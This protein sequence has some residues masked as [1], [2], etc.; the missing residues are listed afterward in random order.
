MAQY[1]FLRRLLGRKTA[2]PAPTSTAAPAA[3]AAT[4]RPGGDRRHAE[5]IDA[6]EGLR[7]LV[8]DDSAT[9][10]A[11]LRKMLLQARY[12]VAG[13]GDAETG[14]EFARR[15]LP[16][17][18]LLDIVLPGMSGFDALRQLRRD[19]ATRHIPVIM[20]SGNLQATE[21]FYVRRIG[22]DDFMK[23]P[24]GRAEVFER[25]RMLVENGRLPPRTGPAMPL[26]EDDGTV[27]APDA[28]PAPAAAQG[29]P[30]APA[31]AGA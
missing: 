6:R 28:G 5:R 14:L 24:F 1:D 29:K 2:D 11:V 8:I 22:A 19:P 10:V 18:I 9:I 20:I 17:L 16:E 21:Q 15:E 3:P 27:A 30:V 31:P 25:I 23:K 7:I 4:A 13:A 26:P 12:T